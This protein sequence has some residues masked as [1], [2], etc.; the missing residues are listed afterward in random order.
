MPLKTEKDN[1]EEPRVLQP[2]MTGLYLRNLSANLFGFLTIFA[3]N[4]FTPLEFFEETR[5][6]LFKEKGRL[7]FFLIYPVVMVLILPENIT[8]RRANI[9]VYG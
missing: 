4:F 9:C 2:G 8:D 7:L 1:M 5:I 6:F 3:L